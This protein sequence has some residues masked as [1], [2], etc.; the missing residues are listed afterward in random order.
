MPGSNTIAVVPSVWADFYEETG[1]PAG[2]RIGGSVYLTGHTGTF[3]D[4]TFP[5]DAESQ[6]RQTFRNIATTL[7]EAGAG[8]SDVVRID[9]YH[10]G[11]RA[12]S[13]T[14][15]AVAREF[16]NEPF[17]AWTAVGVTEFFEPEALVEISCTALVPPP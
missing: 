7:A 4:G 15:M 17:P 8:W 3:D 1:I 12:Q 11:L 5:A 2:L 9:S 13:G 16:L 10:V 14:L 6:I